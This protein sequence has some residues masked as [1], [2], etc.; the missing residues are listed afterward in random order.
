MVGKRRGPSLVAD[1]YETLRHEILVGARAP[2]ER[3]HLNEISQAHGV[4]LSVVREAVTRLASE[5][6]VQA[7]PQLGFRVQEL[8][9]EHLKDLTYIRVQ[10][11]SLALR[12]AI[13][14]GDVAWEGRLVGA[15]H[16][17]SN[18]EFLEAGGTIRE[19][20]MRA[21]R[22]FHV[23]LTESCDSEI[24]RSLRAQFFDCAELYRYW[25]GR[26]AVD[27]DV[28]GEHQAILEAALR[29][30]AD[31]AVR[32]MTHH[33]QRTTEVLLQGARERDELTTA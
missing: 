13:A 31:E 33:I 32:L 9:A 21:H 7:V 10:L 8:S 5:Y 25:S 11:E 29:R 16:V 20:W 17:L 19:Q 23:A 28:P 2:G 3:L 26:A 15:S 22:D 27:R 1:M 18:C 24:L 4:S 14:N 12:S 30:D 6:I